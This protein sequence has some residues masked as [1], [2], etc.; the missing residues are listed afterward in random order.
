VKF[1][2]RSSRLLL[3]FLLLPG[4]SERAK[5]EKTASDLR[6]KANDALGKNDYESAIKFATQA[7]ELEP[8][9]VDALWMRGLAR[10]K[11]KDYAKAEEDLTQAIKLDAKYAPAYRER[12]SVYLAQEKYAAAIEDATTFLQMRPGDEDGLRIRILANEKSG[13][14]AAATADLRE[15]DKI[16]AKR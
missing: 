6:S 8:D 7:L 15:L 1:L 9:H 11:T 4:C 12:A 3:L 10:L 16:K 14:H 13:N 5:A 2:D